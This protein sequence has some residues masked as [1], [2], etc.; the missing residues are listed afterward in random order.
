MQTILPSYSA[1]Q[2]PEIC[3]KLDCG[4]EGKGL[5]LALSYAGLKEDPFASV[6][7]ELSAKLVSRYLIELREK[8]TADYSDFKLT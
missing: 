1:D 7:D 5:R 2:E 4:S 6:R 3:I 8:H